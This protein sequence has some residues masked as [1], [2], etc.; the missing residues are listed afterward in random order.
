MTQGNANRKSRWCQFR[1][2]TLALLMMVAG[3]V[4]YGA[5][6]FGPALYYQLME[7]EAQT[8]P[9]TYYLKDDIQ[10]FSNAAGAKLQ[11]EGQSLR[12]AETS[13]SSQ[14]DIHDR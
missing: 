12:T 4:L 11:A 1:L 8:L 2:R 3:P 9:S 5:F 13:S 14:R 10:F 6:L 7:P